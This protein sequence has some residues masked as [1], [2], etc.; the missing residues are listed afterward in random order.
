MR[1]RG[2]GTAILISLVLDVIL[3]QVLAARGGGTDR[4]FLMAAKAFGAVV[5]I[6]APFIIGELIKRTQS[7]GYIFAIALIMV[8]LV[9][10]ALSAHSGANI[11][12]TVNVAFITHLYIPA[13]IVSCLLIK[14]THADRQTA[15]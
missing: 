13:A 5:G 14:T 7:L 12:S 4:A 8:L 15:V 9:A 1:I 6:I 3:A 11:G 10:T 2:L